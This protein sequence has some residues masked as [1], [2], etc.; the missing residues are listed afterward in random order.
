MT[1]FMGKIL[2]IDLTNESFEEQELSEEVY[3]EYLG[4]YGL[5]AKLIYENMKPKV[6]PLGPE[7]LLGF[8]PGILT[9]SAASLTGRFMVA[10]KSPLTGTWGDANCG[11]YFGP[12][13][14][15][16]GY[17]G[18]ILKGIASTPKYIAIMD[19]EKKILD[20]SEV[21]GLDGVEA[22]EKL[23]GKHPKSQI[24]S[25]GQAGENKS[26]ISGIITDKGRIAARSGLGA[27]MGSKNLKAIV[28]KGD[29]KVEVADNSL[30]L[31]HA[32]EYNK[33][34]KESE[35][36]AI[37]LWKSLGTPWQNDVNTKLGD[38]PI[39]NWGGNSDDHFTLDQVEAITGPEI[40]KY[41]EKEYGCF[42]CP[43]RCGGIVKVPEVDIEES[44]LPEYE[45]CGAFGHM[46][47][48]NDLMSIFKLND[49]C[50]RAGMDS[51]SAGGTIAFAVECFE[52]G[53][54]GL[55]DTNGLMLK[56]GNADAYIE[57]L[58]KM[59]NREG[60]GDIL[61]DG[62]KKAAERIGNGSE[63]YAIHSMGQELAMHSPKYYDSMGTTY[64][65]DPTP[66]RHT[67]AGLDMF[68]SGP[69]SRSNG[70]IE[71]FAFPKRYKRKP[72]P[73][74]EAFKMVVGLAQSL[75]CLGVCQFTLYFQKYPLLE[76]IKGVTGWDVDVGE[77]IKTGL[78][79]QALRQ[80]FTLREGVK[81]AENEIPKRA[82][83]INYK[84][85]YERLSNKLGWNP[86]NGYPLQ[87]TL[88]D[89]NLDYLIKDLY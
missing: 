13:I 49:L 15:K 67:A 12:E 26:L 39:R 40:N 60:I 50:N 34:V 19:G 74:A 68:L 8:F 58:K 55:E 82:V 69:L 7:A 22:E 2:W 9:G 43:V 83:G 5:A 38:T 54:I 88:K 87:E 28:L 27:V 3:R 35:A 45:T 42:A 61:A 20:A 29:K 51:I 63:K 31:E 46:L 18:I 24:A 72:E 62:S 84:Q 66:G 17:D 70:Y 64:A 75:S 76:F 65:F 25:V 21:W 4:G 71:G 59:I 14:K 86:E 89:L 36:G 52:N 79:I 81:I 56:W 30:I 53:I 6:D 48:N 10:G 57:L 1:G 16:C 85:E 73:R 41:K 33:T 78:R 11:G 77:L 23:L 32:K 80:A 47:L 44:H 37:Y